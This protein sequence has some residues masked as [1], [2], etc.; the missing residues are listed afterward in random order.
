MFI[1]R[2]QFFRVR[3]A[4]YYSNRKNALA[5]LWKLLRSNDTQKEEPPITSNHQQNGQ[6]EINN[7]VAESIQPEIIRQTFQSSKEVDQTDL[8]RKEN[9]VSVAFKSEKQTENRMTTMPNLLSFPEFLVFTS[10][11]N[12]Y[13]VQNR[14][15]DNQ[16]H[17]LHQIEFE[18]G[19]KP[20]YFTG[21]KNYSGY[22]IVAFQNGKVGKL[23]M[24]SFQTE[25]NRRKLKNAFNDESKLIFIE[26]IDDNIDL[27]TLSSINKVVL[28]N[29]SQ[30]NP[31]G[32]RNTKGVQVMKQK[33]GS[34]MIKVKRAEQAKL[35]DPEYYRKSECLNVVGYY[36]K[37]GDEI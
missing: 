8:F 19:E 34:L 22:L 29:T 12:V 28:F 23:S 32:S 10:M 25:H 2:W 5:P 4:E 16:Q 33:D 18:V 17:V 11:Q 24:A 13:K 14:G 26:R 20:I 6:E 37:Q 1:S 21:I 27:V 36:L 3:G 31:V 35:N 30:I 15:L 9:Q 7:E